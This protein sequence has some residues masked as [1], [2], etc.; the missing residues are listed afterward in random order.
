MSIPTV[1]ITLKRTPVFGTCEGELSDV[2]E[3]VVY[4]NSP[5]A[6]VV[7]QVPIH[8]EN[9]RLHPLPQVRSLTWRINTMLVVGW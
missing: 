8:I 5:R 9:M 1:I 4:S 2:G 6:T 3:V 7:R